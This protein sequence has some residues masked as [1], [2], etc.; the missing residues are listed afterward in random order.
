MSTPSR[1][2]YTLTSA[3]DELNGLED[4]WLE[5]HGIAP[6]P[7]NLAWLSEE[8]I[9]SFPEGIEYPAVV[10]TED[11]NVSLEWIKPAARIELEV[12]FV[13]R[14]LE[15]Y[16]TNMQADTFVDESF[17]MRNWAGAFARITTLLG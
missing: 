3:I 16:A 10:P 2:H 17:D 9:E 5:G 11:G 15:L 4:G 6:D 13:E 12:N 7:K 1:P 8:L 14:R